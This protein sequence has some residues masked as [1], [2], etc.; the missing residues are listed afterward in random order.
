MYQCLE[1]VRLQC[2][3]RCGDVTALMEDGNYI[4]FSHSAQMYYLKTNVLAN[5]KHEATTQVIGAGYTPLPNCY[6]LCIYS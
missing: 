5:S 3:V 4:I 2:N 6:L 1:N